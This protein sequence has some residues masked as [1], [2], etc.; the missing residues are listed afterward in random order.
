MFKKKNKRAE[1]YWSQNEKGMGE[2]KAQQEH[3]MRNSYLENEETERA[4]RGTR[5]ERAA[6][7]KQ[8]LVPEDKRRLAYLYRAEKMPSYRWLIKPSYLSFLLN[9]SWME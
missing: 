1:I 8:Q 5:A 4:A 7:G 2:R 9:L 6:A 3:K